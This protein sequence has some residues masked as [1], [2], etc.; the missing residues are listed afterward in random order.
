MNTSVFFHESDDQ[1]TLS[2]LKRVFCLVEATETY[3]LYAYAT[4]SGLAAFDL[5]F[6]SDHWNSTKTRWLFG[7]DYGRSQPKA[8]RKIIERPNS[9]VRI[10][11]GDWLAEQPG[12]VPRRVYHPKT[13]FLL[14]PAARKYGLVTGSGNFSSN[15]FRRSIEA[16]VSIFVDLNAGHQDLVGPGLTAAN[17]L[18]NQAT[19]ADKILEPYEERWQSSFSRSVMDQKS[20]ANILG[21]KE[22]FWIEA[23]P[24]TKN[25]GKRKPGNQIDLP[26]GMAR[27]FGLESPPDLQANSV[28]GEVTFLTPV[29]DSVAGKLRLGDNAMEKI[30]LPIP[31]KCGFDIYDGKVLVFQKT[32]N[33]FRLSALEPTEF[34]TAFGDRLSV[35]MAM[36]SHRRFGHFE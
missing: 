13:S 20:D 22:I 31:E 15:G 4:E 35:V 18:W 26:K 6:G 36:K 16:G 8:I 11:D 12:F 30:N 14:Q 9:E 19:P 17:E 29:G 1:T 25:R 24:V 3:G 7:I 33:E 32:G 5:E 34:E 23:G 2:E 21:A 28:I 27:Y 10:H